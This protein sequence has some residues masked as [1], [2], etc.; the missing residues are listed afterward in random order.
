MFF[1]SRSVRFPIS[2]ALLLPKGTQ[3]QNWRRRLFEPSRN[4][5]YPSGNTSRHGWGLNVVWNLNITSWWGENVEVYLL[6]ICIFTYT[7]KQTVYWNIMAILD[8]NLAVPLVHFQ[9]R[10]VVPHQATIRGNKNH[11]QSL[12]LCASDQSPS[13][14]ANDSHDYGFP[15]SMTVEF[16]K[17]YLPYLFG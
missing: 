6:Y 12:V 10:H 1:C 2:N 4:F 3:I 14:I 9:Q 11:F 16:C 7:W 17:C 5:N 13:M 15:P 8:V